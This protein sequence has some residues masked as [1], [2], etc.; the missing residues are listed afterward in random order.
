MISSPVRMGVAGLRGGRCMISGSFG[1]K[2][3]IRP[4]KPAVVMLIHRICTGRI[5]RVTP[6]K[7]A[8]MITRPSP[9]FV[10]RVQT[11]N[12]V[13]LSNTARPSSTAASMELKLSSVSTMSAASLETSVPVIPMATPISACFNAGASF[14]P[15][16]VM[17]TTWPFACRARTSRIFCS[18]VALAKTVVS[19]AALIRSSSVIC[20]SSRPVNTALMPVLLTAPSYRPICPAMAAAVAGWSPVIILTLIPAVLQTLI[21]ATASG[22]G[23]SI[24]ACRPKNRRPPAISSWVISRVRVS[25]SL[26]AKASTRNPFA[27][28]ISTSCCIRR[29]STGTELPCSSITAE[30]LARICSTAPFT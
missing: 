26:P 18:G 15:S 24:I 27:A 22:R 25:I 1:S 4:K 8:A 11:M 21:A 13:R 20:S 6:R 16:P 28:M 23:G 9:R 3:S 5:G 17:A 19:S 2:A 12:F 30:H 29:L 7:M 10:G 14:T